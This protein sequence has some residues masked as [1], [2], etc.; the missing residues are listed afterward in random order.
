MGEG[1]KRVYRLY[2]DTAFWNRLGD[3]RNWGMRRLSYRFLNRAC[4]GHEILISPLV[5]AEIAQTPDLRERL[6]IERMLRKGCTGVVS[7][8]HWAREFAQALVEVERFADRMLVDLTHVGYAVR[9]GA[10]AVVTW[11]RRTLAREKVRRTVQIVCRREGRTAPL[12]GTPEEVAR[13]LGLK[14]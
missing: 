7:G 12:I 4:P 3:S 1:V 5:L 2:L 13:W 11:D 14:M 10:D 6:T 8:E 9:G